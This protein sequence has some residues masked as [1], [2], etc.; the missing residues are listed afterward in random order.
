M[1]ASGAMIARRSTYDCTT[2][3]EDRSVRRKD[4]VL[5]LSGGL[6]IEGCAEGT[7]NIEV[8]TADIGHIL[9]DWPTVVAKVAAV[10]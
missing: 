9:D 1:L 2:Y 3:V 10:T 7:K 5:L 4:A 6:Q 8:E